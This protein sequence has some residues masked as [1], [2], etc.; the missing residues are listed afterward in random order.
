MV[1]FLTSQLVVYI[2]R[3]LTG[4]LVGYYLMLQFPEHE[5]F[6]GLLSIILVISPEENDSKRLTVERVKSNFIGSMVGFLCVV[7]YPTPTVLLIMLGIV[8]TSIICYLFKVMNMSR[9]AIVALLIVLLQNHLSEIY[10]API[11]RFA[12]V[13][14]GCLIGLFITIITSVFIEKIKVLNGIKDE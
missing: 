3:C 13:A 8:F 14:I 10:I 9:V 2:F 11:T 1:K 7:I 4:F 12:T 6:W 5:P